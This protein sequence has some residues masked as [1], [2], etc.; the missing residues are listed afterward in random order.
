MLTWNTPSRRLADGLVRFGLGTPGRWPHP[1]LASSPRLRALL[2]TGVAHVYMD[3]A[4]VEEA[5]RLLVL[6]SRFPEELDGSTVNQPLVRRIIGRY[7]AADDFARYAAE[8]RQEGAGPRERRYCLYTALAGW[9]GLDLARSF[10]AG[11]VW[12]VS[13]QLHMGAAADRRAA[14]TL[15]RWLHRVVPFCLVK[16]P[17][18]PHVPESLLVARDLEREGI[19]VNLTSTFSAR[20]VVTVAL[21]AN[22]ARTN[23]FLGRLNDGLEARGLGEHVTLEAQRSLRRLRHESRTRTQLI[24]ASMRDWRGFVRL[25]GCD[26]FTAPCATIRDFLMQ[27]E[28]PLEA[29]PGGLATSDNDPFDIAPHVVKDLGMDRVAGLWRVERDLLE[30]LLEFRDTRAFRDMTDG[31]DLYAVFDQ[32]GFGDLF[33]FPSTKEWAALEE[34]KLPDLSAERARRLPMDTHYTLLAHA[35]FCRHQ[36]AIDAETARATR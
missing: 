15:G 34:S 7:L 12:E 11:R 20:Q 9:I 8:L 6:E 35:D 29:A 24:A 26:A 13:L 1:R 19:P 10:A 23:V 22:V 33:A 4:D 31:D 16:V 36:R 14:M 17:F 3:S 25:A 27:P 2:G 5:R 28:V 18:M 32:A 30:F 21:L